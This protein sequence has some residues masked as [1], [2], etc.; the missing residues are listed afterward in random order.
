MKQLVNMFKRL[1]GNAPQS[2]S[3]EMRSIVVMQRKAHLFIEEELLVAGE[4]G[5]GKKFD[6]REDPMFFV[7]ADHSALTVVKAGPHIIRVTSFPCRY[8]D[9]DEYAL[10]QLPQPEQKSA[11][12][13]QSCPHS[14]RSVQ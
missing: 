8:A 5:W 1:I 12:S 6:G 13:E 9:D 7:S 4:R 11:W 10:S 3:A 2:E 14:S